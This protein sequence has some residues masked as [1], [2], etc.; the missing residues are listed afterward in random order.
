MGVCIVPGLMSSEWHDVRG[1]CAPETETLALVLSVSLKFPV[2]KIYCEQVR[3][4]VVLPEVA[5]GLLSLL[6]VTLGQ[7][8]L[9]GGPWGSLAS[10]SLKA[11]PF[12]K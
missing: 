12:K 11:S 2:L 7:P 4:F 8:W 5:L 1:R 10:P 9:G 3:R 6:P